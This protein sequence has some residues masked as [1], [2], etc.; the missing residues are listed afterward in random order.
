MPTADPSLDAHPCCRVLELR[1]YTL[2]PGGLD[3][4]ADLFEHHFLDELA[5][6]GMH[7]PG[8]FADLDDPDR[9]VWLRGFPDMAAR[10]RALSDFY[11][12]GGVWREHAAAANA[13]MIDSDDVLLLE[14]LHL[15]AGYPIPAA[16][17]ARVLT[18]GRLV[19]DVLPLARL[20]AAGVPVETL[21]DRVLGAASHE[22]AEVLLVA[23]THPQPNDFAGL[24]VRDERVGGLADPP[25]QPRGAG[26]RPGP[27]GRPAGRRDGAIGPPGRLPDHLSCERG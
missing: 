6:T 10:Q 16:P 26:P 3:T 13:T 4:L 22:G 12:T 17:P 7:V 20:H 25:P 15:G 8:L 11:L 14:P 9:L 1:Q 19:I 21:V 27:A 2:H 18:S 23:V 5:A 24:P